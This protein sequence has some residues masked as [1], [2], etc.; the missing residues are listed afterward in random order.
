MPIYIFV[1]LASRKIELVQ[2]DI[3]AQIAP[4]CHDNTCSHRR[5]GHFTITLE[6]RAFRQKPG[7]LPILVDSR[8]AALIDRDPLLANALLGEEF[9]GDVP[10]AEIRTGDE[11]VFYGPGVPEHFISSNVVNCGDG[12]SFHTNVDY[13]TGEA[14]TT[15]L[16]WACF[17]N[18]LTP[19]QIETLQGLLLV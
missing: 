17:D 5:D 16:I 19:A 8:M 13:S 15:P 2:A 11:P 1:G 14:T 6:K 9:L 10:I 4:L 7:E 12:L 18:P 3:E